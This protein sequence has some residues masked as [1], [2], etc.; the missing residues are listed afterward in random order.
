MEKERR[1]YK[2]F[3]YG[4]SLEIIELELEPGQRIPA[5]V[6]FDKWIDAGIIYDQQAISN[7]KLAKG[8]FGTLL[9]SG[10]KNLY[11]NHHLVT[12]FTNPSS[13]RKRVAFA[14]PRKRQILSIPLSTNEGDFICHK[15]AF[16]CAESGIEAFYMS[17]SPLNSNFVGLQKSNWLRFRGDGSIFVH[18]GGLFKHKKIKNQILKLDRR[19]IIG[20]TDGIR[21]DRGIAGTLGANRSD[22]KAYFRGKLSGNGTVYL[23]SKPYKMPRR[24][25]S[26]TRDI[27]E[28]ANSKALELYK[29]NLKKIKRIQWSKLPDLLKTE[30][31][32]NS[33]KNKITFPSITNKKK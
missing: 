8:F 30:R 27:R 33:L 26:L 15:E 3:V 17:G 25:H 22:V 4:G 21:Y 28:L 11:R 19:T 13:V 31:L 18:V 2:I 1:G 32:K 14:I 7:A 23:Q 6:I 10:K 12:Y 24:A 16:I 20:F 5:R 9:K 29:D